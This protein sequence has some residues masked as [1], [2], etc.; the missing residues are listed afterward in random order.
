MVTKE[1][2]QAPSRSAQKRSAQAIEDL[3]RTLVELPEGAWR[4][5]PLAEDLARELAQARATR[6]HGARRRQLKHLAGMLRKRPEE[7][8]AIQ[9]FLAG[10]HQDQLAAASAFHE[11]EALRERLCGPDFAAALRDLERDFPELDHSAVGRLA[12]A[13]RESDDRRAYRELFRRLRQA[14][15][16]GG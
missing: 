2:D 4:H 14:A 9:D 16:K 10:V 6:E 5:A 13:V 3:A 7:T 11:L 1:H 12:A 15:G 8:G